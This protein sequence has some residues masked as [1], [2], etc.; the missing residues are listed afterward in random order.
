V[1]AMILHAASMVA[2]FVDQLAQSPVVVQCAPN[3]GQDPL[4]ARLFI[5]TLPSVF[6][7]VVAWMVFRWNRKND[8]RRWV[9]ENKE[10]EWRA[11]LELASKVEQF[12]PSVVVGSELIGIVHDPAFSQHLR[13]MTQTVLKC[14]FI[15]E[16]KAQKIYDDLV[17]AQIVN[18]ESKGHIEDFNSNANLSQ[19]LGRPRPL[20]AAQNVQSELISLCRV[21]RKLAAEDLDPEHH[22]SWWK[23]LVCWR[24]RNRKVEADG[25]M[26]AEPQ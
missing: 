9:I 26:P 3:A 5:A 17:K 13:E 21:I 6:A 24:K 2:L 12:T 16:S 23:L 14:V 25:K 22:E 19:A 4:L 18:E 10:T 7:L 11:L 1:E 8:D 15:S 20:Q